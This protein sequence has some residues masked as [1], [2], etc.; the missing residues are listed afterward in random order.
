ML[1]EPT[2]VWARSTIS[3][4]R[5][6]F[7]HRFRRPVHL[8]EPGVFRLW[9]VTEGVVDAGRPLGCGAA[10]GD[11][12]PRYGK[13]RGFSGAETIGLRFAASEMRCLR[14]EIDE[15]LELDAK[16]VRYA[17]E[18]AEPRI[19]RSLFDLAESRSIHAEHGGELLLGEPCGVSQAH[20]LLTHF[21]FCS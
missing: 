7:S 17:D 3:S 10:K 2:P 19:A 11:V 9:D 8:L 6:G 5:F 18:G 12:A 14:F 20:Y 15:I 4:A 21:S 16:A 1:P 13:R